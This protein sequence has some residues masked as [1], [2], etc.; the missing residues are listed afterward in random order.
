MYFDKNTITDIASR[1]VG[2]LVEVGIVPD[3]TDTDDMTELEVQDAIDDILTQEATKLL[4][5]LVRTI[6]TGELLVPINDKDC[7]NLLEE[8]NWKFPAQ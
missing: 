4:L 7:D 1:I 2:H 8:L 6:N 3:C 5:N